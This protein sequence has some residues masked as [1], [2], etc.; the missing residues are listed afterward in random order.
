MPKQ[1]MPA[2]NSTYTRTSFVELGNAFNFLE[3]P[4]QLSTAYD[5][6]TLVV[7]SSF[8]TVPIVLL[9]VGIVAF[10]SLVL[11]HFFSWLC[12]CECKQKVL[13][14]QQIEVIKDAVH[15]YQTCCTATFYTMCLYIILVVH[16]VIYRREELLAG[17]GSSLSFADYMFKQ[18][19]AMSVAADA[20]KSSVALM[21]ADVAQNPSSCIGKNLTSQVLG[22]QAQATGFSNDVEP[23]RIVA[24]S[25]KSTLDL[26]IGSNIVVELTVWLV[27]AV[28]LLSA[29]ALAYN[30]WHRS[31]IGVKFFMAAGGVTYLGLLAA[32]FC[33]LVIT[34]ILSNV[35]M[36]PLQGFVGVAPVFLQPTMTY[37]S[38]CFGVNPLYNHSSYAM[39]QMDLI[40]SRYNS[41]CQNLNT[42]ANFPAHKLAAR[43][44]LEG[45]DNAVRCPKVRSRIVEFIQINVCTQVFNYSS[46]VWFALQSASFFFFLLFIIAMSAYRF[47]DEEHIDHYVETH[48]NAD[49]AHSYQNF[50][51]TGALPGSPM[52]RSLRSPRV[53]SSAASVS[54]WGGDEETKSQRGGMMSTRKASPPSEEDW[55]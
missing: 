8:L 34:M 49:V 51:T 17:V 45:V 2:S 53:M 25:M 41:K 37:Y 11:V 9:V 52:G 30:H 4:L 36:N 50:K 26:I 44:A 47:E 48:F 5:T 29:L 14:V 18:A 3:T 24:R 55:N 19:D 33:F 15:N 46:S 43:Q 20:V 16:L 10:V 7:S 42:V 35:C 39:A 1:V 12:C 6:G 27:Y 32:S 28:P 40:D 22:L 38:S 13:P 21:V 31:E 54:D 23:I